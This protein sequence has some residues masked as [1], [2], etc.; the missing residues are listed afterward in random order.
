MVSCRRQ[1]L[2]PA[3][4][5]PYAGTW[6]VRDLF[7][8]RKKS[9]GHLFEFCRLRVCD[10]PAGVERSI[11]IGLCT[12]RWYPE[13]C[14]PISA[15]S[16]RGRRLDVSWLCRSLFTNWSAEFWTGS[17]V[18]PLPCLILRDPLFVSV[19]FWSKN[20]SG[21]TKLSLVIFNWLL[22][23]FLCSRLKIL[24]GKDHLSYK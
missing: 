21:L 8:A 11:W 13:P 3:H 14:I 9:R 12:G 7:S 15:R 6:F 20:I 23:S 22:P 17:V 10:S 18:S 24:M 1:R 2:K 19:H 5:I 4:V 16:R